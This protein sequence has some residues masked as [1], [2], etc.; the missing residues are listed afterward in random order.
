MVHPVF[1]I[2]IIWTE[3]KILILITTNS[4]EIV[5][6]HY[7][8]S[9]WVLKIF[10]NSGTGEMFLRRATLPVWHVIN[11]FLNIVA[12]AGHTEQPVL[13]QIESTFREKEN[14][15][16]ISCQYRTS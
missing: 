6:L 5:N 1:I 12:H 7:H 8:M 11:T 15:P 9:T 14:G 16:V 13:C 4:G 2:I 3:K 10:P